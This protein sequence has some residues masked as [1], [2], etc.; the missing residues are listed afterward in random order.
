MFSPIYYPSGWTPYFMLINKRSN[1]IKY[2]Q[3][4]TDVSAKVKE[5]DTEKVTNFKFELERQI[6]RTRLSKTKFLCVPCRSEMNDLTFHVRC[7]LGFYNN[8]F[9]Y[10]LQYRNTLSSMI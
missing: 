6:S 8:T 3:S 2:Y 4:I 9:D 1:L 10:S 7:R 5:F